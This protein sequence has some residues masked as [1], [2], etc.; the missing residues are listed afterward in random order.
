MII[1][2]LSQEW[3]NSSVLE[4]LFVQFTYLQIKE[5]KFIRYKIVSHKYSCFFLMV[6]WN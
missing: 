5:K 6:S 1:L 2:D 4:D 3:E